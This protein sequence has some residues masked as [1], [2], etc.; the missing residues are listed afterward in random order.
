MTETVPAPTALVLGSPTDAGRVLDPLALATEMAT[1]DDA[2]RLLR[3]SALRGAFALALPV[4]KDEW[5]LA[6]DRFAIQ[7]LCWRI[8]EGQL[9]FSA[10]AD[11]LADLLPAC[12]VDLQAIYD[13]LHFHVIPSP[14][15]V[16]EGV[17][18]LPA[19]HCLHWRAGKA[20]VTRY[21]TPRFEEPRSGDFES[22]KAEFLALLRQ[23]VAR[24][25]KGAVPACYLSGGTDS[26]TVAGMIRES[27]GNAA[28]G[29]SIG[30]EAEGYDEMSYAR[31]AAKRFGVKHHEYYVTPA[32]LRASMPAVAA[33]YDQ[34]FGNSSAVPAYHCA[35]RARED[36]VLHILAGDG[37]DELFG[38]NAR[39]AKQRLFD[40]YGNWP[41]PLR[42]GLLEPLLLH[43]PLGSLPLAR[44]AASYVEQARVP[45][46]D[47]LEIYNL[48]NRVGASTMLT[49]DV[50]ARVSAESPLAHQRAAWQDADA[51]DPLNR[52]LAFDWRYTLAECDLPK[53]VGSA[54]LAGVNVGFPLLDED[55]L[56]FSMRLPVSYKLRG[57]KLRWFFKEALR[58][59]L[60]DEIIT[61]PKHGFGL[62]FGPWT[63][64]DPALLALAQDAIGSLV[65][66]GLIRDDFAKPLMDKLLPS[67]PGYYGELVWI[68]AMLELWLRQRRPAE[69]WR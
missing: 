8:R 29:Y 17:S 39:Y 61:K 31:I 48:L 69:R 66:R 49:P 6:V 24:Q 22:L 55:L 56:A 14:R 62:P 25:L 41:Q 32:D 67:H 27:S 28:H 2:G 40:L 16:F 53:V 45:M 18:R 5:L 52:T 59:F 42:T 11:D 12:G 3:L 9:A 30:F 13:Y 47:R 43:T 23:G 57:Q 21:W 63:L 35:L 58:G 64:R 33:H 50:L 68:L 46:P 26:S 54:S 4:G 7:T 38:G 19:G 34:P 10:R 51:G 1:L 36:G 65:D 60:P 44:K 15:T 37:G 20:T